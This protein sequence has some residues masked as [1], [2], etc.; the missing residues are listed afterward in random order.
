MNANEW[1]SS[2]LHCFLQC[3]RPGAYARTDPARAAGHQTTRRT[4]SDKKDLTKTVR[5]TPIS[6]TSTKISVTW[7]RSQRS[8]SDQRN[9][10]HDRRLTRTVR[11]QQGSADITRKSH[12]AATEK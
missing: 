11:T 9:I 5:T 8:Q 1:S 3:A 10:N 2:V 7:R 6:A 4:S 12:I